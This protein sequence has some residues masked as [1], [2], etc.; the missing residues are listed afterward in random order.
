MFK[1]KLKWPTFNEFTTEFQKFKKFYLCDMCIN[2][3]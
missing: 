1:I 3:H 2:V